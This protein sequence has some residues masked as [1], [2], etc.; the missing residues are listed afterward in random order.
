MGEILNCQYI[1]RLIFIASS[2]LNSLVLCYKK[3]TGSIDFPCFLLIP[4]FED[5]YKIIFCHHI[6]D[7][8]Q[9]SGNWPVRVLQGHCVGLKNLFRVE[10]CDITKMGF[11]KE[12]D[13]NCLFVRIQ[14][15]RSSYW[16][17]ISNGMLWWFHTYPS[18]IDLD[19]KR[20]IQANFRRICMESFKHNIAYISLE[21]CS[22]KLSFCEWKIFILFFQFPIIP[23]NLIIS[24]LNLFIFLTSLLYSIEICSGS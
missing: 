8:C 17:D 21:I 20:Y 2:V 22:N 12:Q 13:E 9:H 11:L 6:Y 1:Q 5:D 10:K 4:D 19:R 18:K 14:L 15:V 24:F 3:M 16:W 23:L 7:I